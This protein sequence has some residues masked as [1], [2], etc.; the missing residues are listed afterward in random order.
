MAGVG[1]DGGVGAVHGP[2]DA[3]IWETSLARDG[4]ASGKGS[5][6]GGQRALRGRVPVPGVLAG[7][8]VCSP[9]GEPDGGSS[10][11]GG[12]TADRGGS[13]GDADG[14]DRSDGGDGGGGGCCCC[15]GGGYCCCGCGGGG[16][17]GGLSGHGVSLE[18]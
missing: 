10:R 18:D 7:C 11:P 9:E 8:K 17:R 1:E 3:A 5:E 14:G 13:V 12:P 15:S 16:G 6:R 4:G 2:Q